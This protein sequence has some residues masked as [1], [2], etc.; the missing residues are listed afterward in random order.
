MP[1]EEAYKV[2]RIRG[3]DSNFLPAPVDMGLRQRAAVEYVP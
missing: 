2:H 3:R 1:I